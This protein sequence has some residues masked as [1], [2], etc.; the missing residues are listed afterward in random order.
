VT[1]KADKATGIE[2]ESG[3]VNARHGTVLESIVISVNGSHD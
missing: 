1:G 2:A 3:S